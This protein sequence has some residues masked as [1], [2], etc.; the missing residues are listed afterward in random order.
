MLMT[1]QCVFVLSAKVPTGLTFGTGFGAAALSGAAAA[2][3]TGAGTTGVT[4]AGEGAAA[5][6][7]GGGGDSI[8]GTGRRKQDKP[9]FSNSFYFELASCT[10]GIHLQIPGNTLRELSKLT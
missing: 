5:G 3:G 9:M 2:A 8:V 10:Y 6:A 1:A 7:G 4:G